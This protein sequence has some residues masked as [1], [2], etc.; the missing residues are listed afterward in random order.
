[1]VLTPGPAAGAAIGQFKSWNAQAF[2]E[3]GGKVCSL[4]SQPESS[5]GEYKRRGEVFIFVT[6]APAKKSFDRVSF[7]IGYTFKESTSIQVTIGKR[8][9]ELSSGGSAAWA[10]TPKEDRQL[11]Q[12]MR[13]GRTMVVEGTSSRGT[14]TR[15]TYSLYGFSAAHDAIGK[16]CGR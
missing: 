2:D 9:F 11:V 16:V 10:D 12:A 7:E 4:W 8:S 1:M 15:D 3:P 5:E 6:H 14:C 13:G